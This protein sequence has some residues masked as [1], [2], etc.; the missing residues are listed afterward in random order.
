MT[1]S[2]NPD[3]RT[4]VLNRILADAK[5]VWAPADFADLAGRAAIDKVLQRLA[6]AGELRRID[7]GLYDR[8]RTNH[9][10][11]RE[12]VPDYRE[13]IRA[14]TRRDQARFVVDG[15]TA[16]NDL[17]LTTAIP[18]RIEVLV[19]ARLKPIKFGAQQIHFKLA[20]PSRLYW[21]GRP[22]MRIVQALHWLQDVLNNPEERAHV[23]RQLRRL[24]DD[25][26]HGATLRDDLRDGFSALPIWMQNFLREIVSPAPA[27]GEA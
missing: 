25:P 3:L 15:M 5:A 11:G 27:E 21:A 24:L 23:A 6:A 9:L 22:A 26:E 4:R 12:T 8:P 20:A 17:G 19:D 10:T 18:A 13:I 7:R 2:G 16:A 1:D 14:V